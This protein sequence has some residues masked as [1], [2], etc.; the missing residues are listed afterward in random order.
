MQHFHPNGLAI[1]YLRS[2]RINTTVPRLLLWSVA[3]LPEWSHKWSATKF[4]VQYKVVLY[5]RSLKNKAKC[6]IYFGRDPW[7]FGFYLHWRVIVTPAFTLPAIIVVFK[8][9]YR[10][11]GYCAGR[12]YFPWVCHNFR[13]PKVIGRKI[14]RSATYTFFGRDPWRIATY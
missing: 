14:W 9:M 11:H 8:S 1:R 3:R 5:D 4:G 6:Y 13:I 7:R 2:D 10:M 12:L